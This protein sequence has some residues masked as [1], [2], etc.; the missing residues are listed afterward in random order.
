MADV[1][2]DRGSHRRRW[3][4]KGPRVRVRGRSGERRQQR[5][6]DAAGRPRPLRPRSRR[7]RSHHGDRLPHRGRQR[8]Q[9]AALPGDPDDT[10][11]R[12]RLAARR[13]DARGARRPRW[14]RVRRGSIPL[15]GRHR[16]RHGVGGDH[17][18]AGHG[19]PDTLAAQPG[20][21]FAQARGRLVGQRR[22]LHRRRHTPG[23]TTVRSPNT[24]ARCGASTRWPTR[25]N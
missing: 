22:R 17:R 10:A 18:P 13:R 11:R 9:R 19:G 15:R 16:A 2:G 1:R 6:P 23:S 21:P 8:A 12:L 5:E 4:D 20:H 25:W 14:W 3:D 24:T 7:R